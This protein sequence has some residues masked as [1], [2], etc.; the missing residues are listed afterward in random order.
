MK[1]LYIHVG[2]DKCGSSSIQTFLS[3]SDVFK[4]VDGDGLVY[5]ALSFDRVIHGKELVR[6]ANNS[7]HG[8]LASVTWEMI[9]QSP[10][11]YLDEIGGQIL[12]LLDNQHL[13]L[14]HEA[15]NHELPYWSRIN[16]FEKHQLDVTF[17][18]YI[19]PPVAWMNSAWWQWGAWSG[20]EF[21]QWMPRVANA[22]KYIDRIRGFND[23]HWVSDVKVRLLDSDLLCDFAKILQLEKQSYQQFP[24]SNKS[25]NNGL[26][27][28]FQNH[29][30]LRNETASAIDFVLDKQLKLDGRPDWVLNQQHIKDI[31]DQTRESN[32]ALLEFLDDES[33]VKLLADPRYWESEA[34]ADMIAKPAT[35]VKP[36]YDELEQISVA[37]IHAIMAMANQQ[38]ELKAGFYSANIWRDM[39]LHI[40]DINV[41]LAYSLMQEAHR[42]R[43]EGPIIMRKLAEYEKKLNKS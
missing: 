37:G 40:E 7:H 20:Y 42:L 25:L 43:P 29:R 11:E 39:A 16:F 17:I 23:I 26:L 19:R 28:L 30:Y 32:L 34:F 6:R 12:A 36:T 22:V 24:T 31:I 18:F 8:Y 35:G 27:R 21:D 41:Q 1:K 14:S 10:D 4:C 33:Q 38:R 2:F 5:A 13:V 15:W 9:K 3:H